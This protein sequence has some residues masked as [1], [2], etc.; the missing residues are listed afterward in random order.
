MENLYILLHHNTPGAILEN[1]EFVNI[2]NLHKVLAHDNIISVINALD[3]IIELGD[4]VYTCKTAV[5]QANFNLTK[6]LKIYKKSINLSTL[7]K[8]VKLSDC[9]ILKIAMPDLYSLIIKFQILSEE[10]IEAI[11]N[12]FTSKEWKELA[13]FQKLSEKFLIKYAEKLDW[14]LVSQYQELSCEFINKNWYLISWE[15]IFKYKKLSEELLQC[16]EN[17]VNWDLVA[18]NK[19]LTPN[20]MERYADQFDWDDLAHFQIIDEETALRFADRF[21]W[22]TLLSIQNFSRRFITE[23]IERSHAANWRM[24][25]ASGKLPNNLIEILKERNIL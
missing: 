10:I 16:K 7:I 3:N 23:N 17:I 18:R 6:F 19:T 25:A 20:L 14:N 12:N 9:H 1:P 2:H 24:A 22:I 11:C 13:I 15:K 8:N 4:D 5:V 21:S